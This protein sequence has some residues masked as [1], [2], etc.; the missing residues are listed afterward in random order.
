MRP[1]PGRLVAAER[2]RDRARSGHLV[3]ARQVRTHSRS[4][5]LAAPSRIH[6]CP[7]SRHLVAPCCGNMC[8][9][10]VRL[11]AAVPQACPRPR[12]SLLAAPCRVHAHHTFCPGLQR[13]GLC[14]YGSLGRANEFDAGGVLGRGGCS[15]RS[16]CRSPWLMRFKDGRRDCLWIGIRSRANI[17]YGM[18]P[19]VD[20]TEC[21][22]KSTWPSFY[23]TREAIS[24]LLN[25]FSGWRMQHHLRANG[26]R[27]GMT[28]IGHRP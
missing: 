23:Q 8:A 22:S 11:A 28:A 12:P 15:V 24:K 9:R 25:R 2:V 13:L 18:D 7:L 26:G 3:A 19:R 4:R 1:L 5:L 6:A 21:N 10:S 27:A 17:Q 16:Q 14:G 20:V